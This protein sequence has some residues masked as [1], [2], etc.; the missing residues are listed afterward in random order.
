M[1]SSTRAATRDI[2]LGTPRQ[3]AHI[4]SRCGPCNGIDFLRPILHQGNVPT[5]RPPSLTP[6]GQVPH[7]DGAQVPFHCLF[8]FLHQGTR[9]TQN[10]V[11]ALIQL[12]IRH[13]VTKLSQH[14]L[15]PF[16]V[17]LLQGF[18]GDRKATCARRLWCPNFEQ[19]T[20]S[21]L[22]KAH[23]ARPCVHAAPTASIRHTSQGE[24]AERSPFVSQRPRRL[25]CPEISHR[26]WTPIR[27]S[28]PNGPL[29]G[30]RQGATE[31][32]RCE[33]CA[34]RSGGEKFGWLAPRQGT[35]T[36]GAGVNQAFEPAG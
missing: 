1:I 27:E 3:D 23:G 7:D 28:S 15:A 34:P 32:T 20:W 8:A 25:G 26:Q 18:G 9:S 24:C 30:R 6:R 29:V 13:L 31:P 33:A 19:T 12:R 4:L 21:P 22:A 17:P 10:E 14:V 35:E 16:V 2:Q 11:L 5:G 36:R